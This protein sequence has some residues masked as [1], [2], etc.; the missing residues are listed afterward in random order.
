MGNRLGIF[1]IAIATF[2]LFAYQQAFGASLNFY[3]NAV[4][5]PYA[6]FSSSSATTVAGIV[7]KEAGTIYW[8]FFDQDGGHIDS[9]SF[10][11]TANQMY[12]FIWSIEGDPSLAGT[13]GYLLFTIDTNADVVIDTNDGNSMSINSFYVDTSTSD[14][15]Y[16]PTVMVDDSGLTTT[17]PTTYEIALL[18]WAAL[19]YGAV[20]GVV[21]D[22]R[23]YI[24]GSAGGED[25]GI[26]IWTCLDPGSTQSVTMYDTN[27]N[28]KVV[29]M[30]TSRSRMNIIDPEAIADRPASFLDGYIRWTVPPGAS[31][32][33]SFSIIHTSA[34][35]AIQTL[36]AGWGF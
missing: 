20:S 5:V 4:L 19:G 29:D 26:V 6:T 31:C 8:T 23:Y 10:S 24:D 28:Y 9:G 30:D 27:S 3:S 34:F 12:P 36:M 15:A 18:A 33:Y 22:M 11:V 13:E 2:M 1:V 21:L 32:A 7:V 17:D 35:G 25:T 14:V 16:I